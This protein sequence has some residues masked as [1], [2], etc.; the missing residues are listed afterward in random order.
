MGRE[1]ALLGAKQVLQ[2]H[3]LVTVYP[4]AVEL[5]ELSYSDVYVG[6]CCK[7]YQLAYYA[8]D[9]LAQVRQFYELET[10]AD[11]IAGGYPVHPNFQDYGQFSSSLWNYVCE[12]DCGTPDTKTRQ[13]VFLVDANEVLMKEGTVIVFQVHIER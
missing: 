12:P 7:G 6:N 4:D 2:P 9:S 5:E 10:G 1:L 11:F 3:S 13:S 8:Q